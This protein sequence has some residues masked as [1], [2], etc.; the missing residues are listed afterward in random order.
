[1]LWNL[2]NKELI[3]GFG[4][5]QLPRDKLVKQLANFRIEKYGITQRAALLGG[6]KSMLRLIRGFQHF[7][8][9]T[10]GQSFEK[11]LAYTYL[12]LETTNDNDKHSK[13]NWYRRSLEKRMTLDEINIASEL[14]EELISKYK[15]AY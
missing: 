6:E 4:L 7:D 10:Q 8:P 5:E 15:K 14:A 11:S 12:L 13:A 1:M 2:S 9:A 3:E